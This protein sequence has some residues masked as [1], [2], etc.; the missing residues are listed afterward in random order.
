MGSIDFLYT[1]S[2]P[3]TRIAGSKQPRRGAWFDTLNTVI[4]SRKT[5]TDIS[6]SYV[7]L[8]KACA[9]CVLEL[10][11]RGLIDKIWILSCQKLLCRHGNG[12]FQDSGVPIIVKSLGK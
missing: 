10:P 2:Q 11:E 8:M 1:H 3:L 9:H 5:H 4:D 12:R 6:P 7:F